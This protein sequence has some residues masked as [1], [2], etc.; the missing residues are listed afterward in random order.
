MSDKGYFDL[1]CVTFGHTESESMR[2]VKDDT[3]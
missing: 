1:M 3:N 2:G